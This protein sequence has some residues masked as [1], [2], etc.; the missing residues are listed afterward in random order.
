MGIGMLVALGVW[1]LLIAGGALLT[2]ALF[3]AGNRRASSAGS[4]PTP[5]QIA[6]LRYARGE[7]T[8]E[9]YDLILADLRR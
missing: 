9:E 2:R 8:R 5:R 3:R 4:A 6:D 1:I 7:I